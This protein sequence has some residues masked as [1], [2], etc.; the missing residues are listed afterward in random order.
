MT[1][2][3]AVPIVDQT[4]PR[5]QPLQR[6]TADAAVLPECLWCHTPIRPDEPR[7]QRMH[8]DCAVDADAERRDLYA[9]PF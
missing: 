5:V 9:N 4:E 2:P 8:E 1:D 7:Y 6:L 3:G